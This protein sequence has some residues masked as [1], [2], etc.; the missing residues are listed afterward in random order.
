[1]R[2]LIIHLRKSIKLIII[3]ALA[4]III[5]AILYLLFKPMYAV[6]LNGEIIGY[7]DAKKQLE[8]QI[9]DYKKNGDGDKIAFIEIDVMPEYEII[10]SKKDL[11]ADEKAV[12]DTVIATGTPYYKSYAILVSGEEKYYVNT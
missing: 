11:K 10:Y 5:V 6:R 2:G 3:L 8:E 7:T 4:L 1:M 12:F 9:E